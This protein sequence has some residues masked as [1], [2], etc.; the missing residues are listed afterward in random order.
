MNFQK[1]LLVPVIAGSFALAAC[2]AEEEAGLEEGV[3]VEEGVGAV[4]GDP[5]DAGVEP[6]PL[7][8]ETGAAT[9]ILGNGID[10]DGDGLIDEEA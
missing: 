1:M 2:G 9:E 6:G 4:E 10:D 8:A 5:L 7:P 3:G